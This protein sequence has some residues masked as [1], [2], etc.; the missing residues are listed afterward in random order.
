MKRLVRARCDGAD[1]D[2]F[3]RAR[4]LERPKHEAVGQAEHRGICADADGDRG[5]RDER[6]AGV[7]HEHPRA[8]LQILQKSVNHC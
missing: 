8:V 4:H 6:E 7:L 2:D 3:V 5:D 1:A